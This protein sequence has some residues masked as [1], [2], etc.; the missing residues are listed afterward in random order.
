M[1]KLFC[2]HETSYIRNKDAKAFKG[3]IIGHKDFAAFSNRTKD[4]IQDYLI[5]PEIE[6]AKSEYGKSYWIS[7]K[8]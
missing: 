3:I 8:K 6:P 1:D 4:E 7:W 2:G 5:D